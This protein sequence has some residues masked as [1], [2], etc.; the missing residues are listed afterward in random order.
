[1]KPKSDPTLRHPTA[2]THCKRKRKNPAFFAHRRV[3]DEHVRLEALQRDV[4]LGRRLLVPPVLP[5][6]LD[7]QRTQSRE[8]GRQTL[9][10]HVRE[11]APLDARGEV[12]LPHLS[13]CGL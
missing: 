11:R 7:V 5:G 2:F 10:F 12:R 13:A 8:N 9:Q 1:M 6:D 4:Q 3:L